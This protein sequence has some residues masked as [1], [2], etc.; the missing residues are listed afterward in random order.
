LNRITSFWRLEKLQSVGPHPASFFSCSCP[1]YLSY[2]WCKHCVGLAIK[3]NLV[4]VPDMWKCNSIEQAKQKGRPK[5]A[6]HCL[7]K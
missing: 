7:Q 3:R 4:S 6:G 2:A 1:W 5:G